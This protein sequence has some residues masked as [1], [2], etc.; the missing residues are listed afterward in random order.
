MARK[1]TREGAE[2]DP[3]KPYLNRDQKE[4]DSAYE[5]A[6]GQKVQRP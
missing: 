1:G 5:R 4:V 2:M 3:M 6:R